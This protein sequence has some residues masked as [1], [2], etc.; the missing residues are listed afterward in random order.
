MAD[1]RIVRVSVYQVDI[2]LRRGFT[3]AD[4]SPTSLA[5]VTILKLTTVDSIEGWGEI[6]P[7]GEGTTAN[8]A[9]TARE[10]IA[11]LATEVVGQ[12]PSLAQDLAEMH[13][14]FS[15]RHLGAWSAIDMAA[16]DVLAKRARVPAYEL[17]GG[18]HRSNVEVSPPDRPGFSVAAVGG[19]TAARAEL[20]AS[21]DLSH[22]AESCGTTVSLAALA[23]LAIAVP[24]P[25]SIS[26]HTA[27]NKFSLGGSATSVSEGVLTVADRSG[28]IEEPN[29]GILGVPIASYE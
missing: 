17:L 24:G 8:S 23:H 26:D 5:D 19:L 11:D 27:N 21:S 9:E 18:P 13:E 1:A 2:P 3:L 14:A 28:M 12:A 20:D 22:I 25:V 15:R 7:L 29:L 4:G 6:T 16:W 10:A